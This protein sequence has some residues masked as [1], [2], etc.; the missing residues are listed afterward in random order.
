MVEEEEGEHGTLPVVGQVIGF[1]C[2]EVPGMPVCRHPVPPNDEPQQIM[3]KEDLQL[4]QTVLAGFMNGYVEMTVVEDTSSDW[5]LLN[6]DMISLLE[7][8]EKWGWLAT[9]FVNKKAIQKL[10]L[11]K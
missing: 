1:Q 8:D 4:G 7:F 9:G 11:D 10:R 3:K 2:Y 5:Y 6:E